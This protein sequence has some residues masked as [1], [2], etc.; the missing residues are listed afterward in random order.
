M[1]GLEHSEVTLADGLG[2]ELLK[3]LAKEVRRLALPGVLAHLFRGGLQCVRHAPRTLRRLRRVLADVLHDGPQV[4]AR[5]PVNIPQVPQEHV[6]FEARA[7]RVVPGEARLPGPFPVTLVQLHLPL[8]G[9]AVQLLRE[10]IPTVEAP[11]LSPRTGIVLRRRASAVTIMPATGLHQRSHQAAQGPE[12]QG[13]PRRVVGKERVQ[14]RPQVHSNRLPSNEVGARIHFHVVS[15]HLRVETVAHMA[16]VRI[17]RVPLRDLVPE[18]LP[19]GLLHGLQALG[20]SVLA[21]A[22][23]HGAVAKL[24]RPRTCCRRRPLAAASGAGSRARLRG[25][26]QHFHGGPG[27]TTTVPSSVRALPLEQA[28]LVLAHTGH[29][30]VA[31]R[32]ANIVDDPGSHPRVLGPHRDSVAVRVPVLAILGPSH[33]EV[34]TPVAVWHYGRHDDLHVQLRAQGDLIRGQVRGIPDEIIPHLP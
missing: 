8:T 10:A 11:G 25:R 2:I 28:F 1:H 17:A 21:G 26:G 22:T 15:A 29:V 14:Q 18:T 31:A 34:R 16:L 13:P 12:V 20:T 4:Q 5:P 27:L 3:R 9:A 24:P 19:E 33:G 30:V 7:Q 6:R 23:Q 32:L